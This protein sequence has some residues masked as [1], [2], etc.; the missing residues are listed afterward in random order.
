MHGPAQARFLFGVAAALCFCVQ[1]PAARGA[2]RRSPVSEALPATA[3]AS[4][5]V[6]DVRTGM[7]LQTLLDRQNFS[8]GCIDGV[9]GRKTR[10]ALRAWQRSRGAPETGRV[11]SA[12]RTAVGEPGAY[13][14]RHVVSAEELAALAPIPPTWLGKSQAQRLGYETL[15]ESLAEESHASEDAI[16]GLNPEAGWPNPAQGT[17]LT[18]PNPMPALKRAAARLEIQLGARRLLAFDAADRLIALFPCSI[19]RDVAK[20]PIGELKIVNAAANPT[21]TFDPAL[22]AESDDART[23]TGKLILP[24][25]PNSPVGVVWLSLNAPGYGIHGTPRPED[26]GSAESHGCFR[27][28]N[29]NARKLLSMVSIGTPVTIQ[30]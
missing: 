18:V 27:L 28:A 14:T 19:A 2:D 11:D 5:S 22:F 1:P 15:L 6:P 3:P 25:G 7:A 21:Y 13:F 12:L 17:V 24:P 26:I 8:C 16:R 23:L 9:L 10:E 4:S 20:R 29:W 30:P